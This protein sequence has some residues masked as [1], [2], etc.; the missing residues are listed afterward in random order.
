MLASHQLNGGEMKFKLAVHFNVPVNHK[1][2]FIIKHPA[3]LLPQ[4]LYLH[5]LN[6]RVSTDHAAAVGRFAPIAHTPF[7]HS[8]QAG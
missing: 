2:A 1:R 4:G 6:H 7:S 3:L 8:A 5:H